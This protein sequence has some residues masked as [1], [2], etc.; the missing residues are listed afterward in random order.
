M[1]KIHPTAV[2]ED[3]AVLA[4]SCEIEMEALEEEKQTLLSQKKELT[5]QKQDVHTRSSLQ[6]ETVLLFTVGAFPYSTSTI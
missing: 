3:G 5:D 1:A 2:V 6:A 4:E